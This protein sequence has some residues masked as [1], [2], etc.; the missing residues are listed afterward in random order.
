MKGAWLVLTICICTML[1]AG[2]GSERSAAATPAAARTAHIKA[3]VRSWSLRLN[4]DDNAGAAKLFGLPAI[5]I[6]A[7]YA[8]RLRTRAQ[9]T[10]WHKTL[11]CA[12]HIVSI[13]VHGL[14]A[15]AIFRLA[16]RPSSKC[17]GPGELAA[18]RFTF[19]HG[20]IVRWEQIPVPATAGPP[21]A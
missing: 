6:Q 11:P 3:V 12:G 5:V 13:T 21:T 4:A 19:A 8:F 17:D 14:V 16:N 10:E 7:P 18:A 9:L 2:Y 1:V 20:K 15:D